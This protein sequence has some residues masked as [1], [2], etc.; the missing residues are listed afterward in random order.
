MVVVSVDGEYFAYFISFF[1]GSPRFIIEIKCSALDLKYLSQYLKGLGA[2]AR[3]FKFSKFDFWTLI[4]L[5]AYYYYYCTTFFP[6]LKLFV[7]TYNWPAHVLLSQILK[8]R[9]WIII[10]SYSMYNYDFTTPAGWPK[11]SK[12]LKPVN[13]KLNNAS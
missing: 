10:H 12:L 1:A 8:T 13:L 9:P 4:F 6:T 2:C 5:L 11:E 3:F 7:I